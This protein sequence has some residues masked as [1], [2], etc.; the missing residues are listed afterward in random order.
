LTTGAVN[1]Y[2]Q[3]MGREEEFSL[4]EILFHKTCFAIALVLNAALIVAI[5]LSFWDIVLVI[6]IGE[7]I[8]TIAF[9]LS[10][11]MKRF[12][13]AW[14]MVIICGYL[15]L[16]TNF[17][18]NGGYEGP[19]LLLSYISLVFLSATTKSQFQWIWALIHSLIFGSIVIYTF[20]VDASR[21]IEYPSQ[22]VRILDLV[23]SYI[24]GAFFIS[25][26]FSMVRSAYEKQKERAIL[27]HKNILIKEQEL[28]DSNKDLTRILSILAHDVRN[29]LASIEG[30][31]QLNEAGDLDASMRASLNQDL[32]KLVK[33]TSYMLDDM[34]HWSKGQ[35][36]G[37]TTNMSEQMLGPWLRP[38]LEHM[39]ALAKAKNIRLVSEYKSTHR[40]FVDP[41][42]TTVILRNLLQNAIKFSPSQTKISLKVKVEQNSLIIKVTDEGIGITQQELSKLFTLNAKS[43]IGTQQELGSGLGLLLCK[44]YT[45]AQGGSI[46]AESELGKGSTFTVCLPQEIQDEE[47]EQVKRV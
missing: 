41:N 13:W 6:I 12:Y 29:P 27:Q 26:F 39:E 47:E 46:S 37:H 22:E 23:L 34:L 25:M 2:Q 24:I 8:L 14:W 38:T 11:F 36:H 43:K 9:W 21:V 44:D 3:L 32:L 1:I 10:R 15:F 19:T 18:L 30:Y 28:K 17:F 45:E 4:R 35:L 7:I 31:L 33:G 20:Y 5:F 40:V 16:G 42:M